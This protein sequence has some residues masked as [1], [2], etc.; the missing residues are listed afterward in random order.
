[1]G[2]VDGGSAVVG[3]V[4]KLSSDGTKLT[5]HAKS[6]VLATGGYGGNMTML[7]ENFGDKIVPGAIASDQGEGLQMAWKA[8]AAKFGERTARFFFT[9]PANEANQM[10]AGQDIASVSW[11]WESSTTPMNISSRA[12]PPS[13][14]RPSSS[15]AGSRGLVVKAA[16]LEDLGAKAGMKG[17]D[18]TKTIAAYKASIASGKDNQHFKDARYLFPFDKG[19]YY[20]FK[21]TT[22]LLGTLGGV[23]IDENI[24]ASNAKDDPIP[25]LYVAGADAGGMYGHDYVQVEGGTLGFAY[26][27]GRLAGRN[28]AAS[29]LA[30]K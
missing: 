30:A 19:P 3:V 14:S 1:M 28:A 9:N 27:S 10:A 7:K 26:A 12:R 17:D 29:A 15:R 18:F 20:A 21:F 16:K 25:G 24:R 23:K 6:V 8:G 13:T 4:A 22:R 5:V 2:Y 11:K